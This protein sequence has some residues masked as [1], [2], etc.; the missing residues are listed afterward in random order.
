MKQKIEEKESYENEFLDTFKHYSLK[1]SNS[2]V[3][4]AIKKNNLRV[5]PSEG[6]IVSRLDIK[7]I[8]GSISEEARIPT[9]S[10]RPMD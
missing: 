10:E 2:K 5:K 4:G 1:Y 9:F 7:D 6:E 3:V 8:A